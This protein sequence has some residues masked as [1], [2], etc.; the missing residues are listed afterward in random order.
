MTIQ[1]LYN[2]IGGN[3][4][5]AVRVMK[6]DRLIDKF[7]RRLKD[8]KVDEKLAEAGEAMD[9]GRACVPTWAWTSWPKPRTR[10]RRNSGPAA[11]AG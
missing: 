8:S 10:S 3:Y 9:A 5:Q 6:L 11:R 4:D 1:E 2:A 7:V